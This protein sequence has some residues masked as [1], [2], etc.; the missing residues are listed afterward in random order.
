LMKL[1]CIEKRLGGLV[2]RFKGGTER[3]IESSPGDDCHHIL[4]VRCHESASDLSS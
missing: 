1:G 2:G 4:G 3:G